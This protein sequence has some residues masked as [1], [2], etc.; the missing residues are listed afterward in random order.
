MRRLVLALALAFTVLAGRAPAAT[1]CAGDLPPPKLAAVDK[2][3]APGPQ[4]TPVLRAGSPAAADFAYMRELA[5]QWRMNRDE[6]ALKRLAAYFDAWVGVYRPSFDPVAEESLRGF[7]DAYAVAAPHLPVQVPGRVRPF[8]YALARGYLQRLRAHAPE[9]RSSSRASRA[10]ELAAMAAWALA[11][12]NLMAQARE[13]YLRQLDAELLPNGEVREVARS[14]RLAAAVDELDPL[15]RAAVAAN[16]RGQHWLSLAGRRGVSLEAALDWL[17]PWAAG[18]RWWREPG[19]VGNSGLWDRT[20]SAD[21]Y[22]A[23]SVV[24]DRYLATAKS[25]GPVPPH[26]IWAQAPCGGSS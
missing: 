13:A 1:V 18:R 5:L 23:A 24:D 3:P 26:W 10:V 7:I 11:D 25:A 8:L 22:W 14:H 4:A 17:E 12:D 19:Q 9:L 20:T 6:D 2:P 16:N 15:A 21:L